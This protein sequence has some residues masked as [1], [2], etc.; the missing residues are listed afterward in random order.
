MLTEPPDRRQRS[1]SSITAR[2]GDSDCHSSDGFAELNEC[3]S[4]THSWPKSQQLT[5]IAVG[6]W[7]SPC[8]SPDTDCYDQRDPHSNC[9]S[10]TDFHRSTY[11]RSIVPLELKGQHTGSKWFT[12]GVVAAP[13][14]RIQFDFIFNGTRYR[15]SIKRPPSAANLRRA[16]ERLERLLRRGDYV[17]TADTDRS[18]YVKQ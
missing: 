13:R 2:I 5:R 1:T 3:P 6:T 17:P 10:L 4:S 12:G 9:W 11:A 16:R 7:H 14:G 18:G 15:P 8:S